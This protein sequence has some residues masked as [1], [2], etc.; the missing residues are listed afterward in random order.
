M[1]NVVSGV[2]PRFGQTRKMDYGCLADGDALTDNDPMKN[3]P[4]KSLYRP[5]KR[6]M[7]YRLISIGMSVI[8]HLFEKVILRSI[9]RGGP[10]S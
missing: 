6:Q 7:E 2:P 9:K 4:T 10:K 5:F 3:N 1:V 8:A